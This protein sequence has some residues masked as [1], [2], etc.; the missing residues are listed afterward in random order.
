MAVKAN[1]QNMRTLRLYNAA[2]SNVE[3]TEGVPQVMIDLGYGPEAIGEG[4]KLVQ[5]T[6]QAFASCVSNKDFRVHYYDD[7]AFKKQELEKMYEDHRERAR[8]VY[9]NK[10]SMAQLLAVA[11]SMPQTYDLWIETV[12]KFYDEVSKDP[13]ILDELSQTK[14]MQEDID[15]GLAKIAEVEAAWNENLK[16]KGISQNSTASKDEAFV[17]LHNWMKGFYIAAKIG[18]KHKPQLIESLGKVVRS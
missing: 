3:T 6:R 1:K 8:L 13:V 14:I 10:R 9:R 11:G 15:A 7:F 18:L 12:R 17:K 16:Y 2:L 4:K 5:E